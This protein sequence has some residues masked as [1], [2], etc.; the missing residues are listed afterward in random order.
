MSIRTLRS[1][2]KVSTARE[3]HHIGRL[4][5]VVLSHRRIDLERP[6]LQH[7][8]AQSPRLSRADP[9]RGLDVRNQDARLRWNGPRPGFFHDKPSDA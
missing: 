5:F 8:H 1:V 9:F 4:N 6:T 3:E 7:A 2:Q